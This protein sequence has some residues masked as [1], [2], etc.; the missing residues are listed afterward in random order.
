ML[1]GFGIWCTYLWKP[2]FATFLQR[3]PVLFL[4][5]LKCCVVSSG[6]HNIAV[7]IHISLFSGFSIQ[8][9]NVHCW[10]RHSFCSFNGM[11]SCPSQAC[12]CEVSTVIKSATD[13]FTSCFVCLHHQLDLRSMLAAT[14]CV[15]QVL[16]W[17]V[18]VTYMKHVSSLKCNKHFKLNTLW[19]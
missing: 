13:S 16:V 4:L 3:L 19:L 1:C 7:H 6:W 18:Y 14:V 10:N 17:S 2:L 12:Y 11:V 9:F 8:T 15:L 5:R